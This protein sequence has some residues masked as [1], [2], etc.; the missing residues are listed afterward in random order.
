M[1]ERMRLLYFLTYRR[2]KFAANTELYVMFFFFSSS[3][4]TRQHSNN[5]F[6]VHGWV[7]MR[8]WVGGWCQISGFSSLKICNGGRVGN[9]HGMFKKTFAARQMNYFLHENLCF[10]VES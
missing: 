3:S 1:V 2:G 8:V 10:A 6:V 5:L 4:T 9:S 7:C